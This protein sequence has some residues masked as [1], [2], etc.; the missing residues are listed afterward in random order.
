[1]CVLSSLQK[2]DW[3]HFGPLGFSGALQN[4]HACFWST[5]L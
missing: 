5:K 1:V 4:A 3:Y 2:K